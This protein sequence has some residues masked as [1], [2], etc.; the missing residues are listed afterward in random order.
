MSADID[1]TV[2][3]KASEASARK[4]FILRHGVLEWGL[5]TG[6]VYAVVMHLTSGPD[7][8]LALWL[9]VSLVVFPLGGILWGRL[10]LR[11]KK[12]IGAKSL[13]E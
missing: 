10:M 12:G 11:F 1:T 7:S 9:A 8:N 5:T 2:P 3:D 6:V 4:A 13:A